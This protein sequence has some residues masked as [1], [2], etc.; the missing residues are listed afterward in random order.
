MS[1]PRYLA[2]AFALTLFAN[3]QHVSAQTFADEVAPP[4]PVAA[5]AP[6]PVVPQPEPTAAPRPANQRPSRV[7]PILLGS[8]FGEILFLG[9]AAP[10][11]LFSIPGWTSLSTAT[12]AWTGAIALGSVGAWLGVV[13]ADAIWGLRGHAWP[14][15]IGAAIGGGLFISSIAIEPAFNS[16]ISSDQLFIWPLIPV[17][18]AIIA[19]EFAVLLTPRRRTQAV[20]QTPL[21]FLPM[22]AQERGGSVWGLSLAGRF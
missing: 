9:I 6:E 10:T 5:P 22:I 2:L 21:A 14:A 15:A 3:S 1:A 20:V 12:G 13:G 18:S 8:L 16:P 19:N 11:L 17:A 7:G 4:T